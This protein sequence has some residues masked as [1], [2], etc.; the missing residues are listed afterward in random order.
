LDGEE[1][2]TNAITMEKSNKETDE[3]EKLAGSY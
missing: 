2:R 3:S 1:V